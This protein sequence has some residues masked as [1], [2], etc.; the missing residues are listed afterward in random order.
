M[1][2]KFIDGVDHFK[3]FRE[4]Q[5]NGGQWF[6]DA[7]KYYDMHMTKPMEEVYRSSL[8]ESLA[9]GEMPNLNEAQLSQLGIKRYGM[10]A[11]RDFNLIPHFPLIDTIFEKIKG[12][13]QRMNFEPQAVDLSI[14]SKNQKSQAHLRMLQD[15]LEHDFNKFKEGLAKEYFM[16]YGVTDV[17]EFSHEDQQDMQAEIDSRFKNM[18]PERINEYF[19]KEYYS[20]FSEMAQSIIDYETDMKKLKKHFEDR[21]GDGYLDNCE[22]SYIYESHGLPRIDKWNPRFFYS[23]MAPDC[24]TIE[25]GE[26]CKAETWRTPMQIFDLYGKYI[27]DSDIEKIRPGMYNIGLNGDINIL[28]GIEETL[29]ISHYAD[30]YEKDPNRVFHIDQRTE[31]GQQK[32]LAYKARFYGGNQGSALIRDC[33]ITFKTPIYMKYVERINDGRVEYSWRHSDYE[34]NPD[35]DI[36]VKKIRSVKICQARCIGDPL[37]EI[38]IQAGPLEY[39]WADIS[40]PR[41]KRHPYSGGYH[42]NVINKRGQM[43]RR[44]LF[45]KGINHQIRINRDA[46]RL[47]EEKGFNVGKVFVML[48]EAMGDDI[49]PDQFFDT[50]KGSRLINVDASKISGVFASALAQSGRVFTSV[51]MSNNVAVKESIEEIE[52]GYKRMERSMGVDEMSVNPYSTDA[53]LKI[54]QENA[55][56]ATFDL[57]TKHVHYMN[58]TLQMYIDFCH[59]V[60]KKN[61]QVLD[62]VLNDMSY[63]I[64]LSDEYLKYAKPGVFI[65]NNIQDQMELREAKMDI[66]HFVQNQAFEMIP[67]YMRLKTARNMAGILNASEGM[68]RKGQRKQEEIMASQ[69]EQAK[70]AADMRDKEL[71]ESRLHE[72][73]MQERDI[74]SDIEREAIRAEQWLNTSDVNRNNQNDLNE[75]AEKQRYFDA[76]ENEKDR[77][78]K[79]KIEQMKQ[80]Q[81]K[82]RP[83]LNQKG[84]KKR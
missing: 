21:F 78:L 3:S 22:V 63:K 15:Y 73:E 34:E 60:Y 1:I 18:T 65:E 56:N 67:D 10:E 44:G 51:D 7:H 53:N 13:R 66:M 48:S 6:K 59:Y 23:W 47:E 26:R 27:K 35:I 83:P 55:S 36:S 40:D 77:L 42:G 43:I 12:I 14:F 20:P 9:A 54:G 58:N 64:L 31:E 84:K 4:K 11:R 45:D 61:P 50:M 8:K 32:L 30:N 49:T 37:S 29:A 68:A 39:D 62:W 52:I 17:A 70:M 57:F 28:N 79:L 24:L 71:L 41:S 25:E 81:V 82:K 33:H 38:Y 69:Q 72:K 80:S 76:N 5:S 75:N 46:A 16:Q 74:I 19:S 2:D